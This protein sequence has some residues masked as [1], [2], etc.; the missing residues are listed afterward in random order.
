VNDRPT[1]LSVVELAMGRSPTLG[2]GR[3]VCVDGPAGSGKTTW[4]AGIARGFGRLNHRPGLDHRD[5]LNHRESARVVHMDDLYAGWSGL[6]EVDAQLSGLLLP[7]AEGRA[8]SFRR[9]DWPTGRFAEQVDVEPRPL[10]VLEGVGAGSLR[11]AALITVLVWVEAPHDLRMRRGIDRD[12]EAFA[13][14]WEQWARDEAEL[15]VRDRTR[16]RADVLVDSTAPYPD[17]SINR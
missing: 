12:G 15:F 8:G 16:D 4:A 7:L 11:F 10:L 3:L 2:S 6:A 1:P 17:D 9:Y 5:G 14:H 13:P